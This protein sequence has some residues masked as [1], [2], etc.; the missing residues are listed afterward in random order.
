MSPAR[1]PGRC[2]NDGC[3]LP[4]LDVCSLLLSLLNNNVV[5]VVKDC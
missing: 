1:I 4:D 5:R 3:T 2:F